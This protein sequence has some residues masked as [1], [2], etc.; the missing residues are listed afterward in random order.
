[1]SAAAGQGAS[2][3]QNV[4]TNDPG[5]HRSPVSAPLPH[6]SAGR[7]AE[8]RFTRA[9]QSTLRVDVVG[10]VGLLRLPVFCRHPTLFTG[11][12]IGQTVAGVAG[13]QAHVSSLSL[14]YSQMS[15]MLFASGRT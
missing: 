15:C 1:M 12:A 9:P 5:Q 3:D 2:Q 13:V 10:Q 4:Y 6:D 11:I 7:D 14:A 8:V